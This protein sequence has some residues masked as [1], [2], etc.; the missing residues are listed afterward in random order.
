MGDIK[1]RIVREPPTEYP[2]Y[3]GQVLR[4]PEAPRVGD[5]I[6]ADY[7]EYDNPIQSRVLSVTWMPYHTFYDIAI[8]LDEPAEY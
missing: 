5:Y 6:I 1:A 2:E 7:D 8:E 3:D 4:L